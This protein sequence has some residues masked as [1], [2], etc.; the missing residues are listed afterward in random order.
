[1]CCSSTVL[2][3]NKDNHMWKKPRKT[4]LPCQTLAAFKDDNDSDD[5]CGEEIDWLVMAKKTRHSM[6]MIE[7]NEAIS[8]RLTEQGVILAEN[9]RYII[10][11]R[12]L[13]Y[14]AIPSDMHSLANNELLVMHSLEL[15]KYCSY[16][17]YVQRNVLVSDTGR[18]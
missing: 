15:Y 3:Y 9:E 12:V 1:M 11:K 16:V 14:L 17:T 13:L 2:L 8:K 6:Q 4:G 10:F 18:L 5:G 7:D